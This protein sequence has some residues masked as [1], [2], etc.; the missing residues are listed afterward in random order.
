MPI[1][2]INGPTI[3][4]GESLSDAVDCRGGVIIKITMPQN[5][6]NGSDIT[7]QTS[8]DDVGYN[9]IMK[10]NGQEVT[11]VAVPGTAIIGM[12]LITGFIKIRGGTRDHPTVQS[13][14]R[15]FAV[16]V[17]KPAVLNAALKITPEY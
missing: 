11:C 2:V 15:T 1:E 6:F 7:F 16:A 4:P 8:S 5:G 12:D 17:L 14:I 10:P 13:D 9:D 3:A